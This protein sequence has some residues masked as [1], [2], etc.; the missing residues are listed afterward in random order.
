M[1][2]DVEGGGYSEWRDPRTKEEI[3]RDNEK[4]KREA[5]KGKRGDGFD[6]LSMLFNWGK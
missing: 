6:L 3:R 1:G 5:N 2:L 4:A